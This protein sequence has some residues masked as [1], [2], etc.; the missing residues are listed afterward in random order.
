MSV[1]RLHRFHFPLV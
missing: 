1:F